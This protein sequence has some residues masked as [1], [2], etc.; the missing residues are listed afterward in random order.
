MGSHQYAAQPIKRDS[1]SQSPCS[2][3]HLLPQFS[4][5]QEGILHCYPWLLMTLFTAVSFTH[6]GGY[7]LQHQ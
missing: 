4:H 3:R 5:L 2:C 6:L 7:D 1:S